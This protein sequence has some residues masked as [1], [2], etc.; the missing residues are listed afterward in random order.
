ME[1]TAAVV[2]YGVGVSRKVGIER[3]GREEA[4]AWSPRQDKL[5]FRFEVRFNYKSRLKFISEHDD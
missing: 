3:A 4:R 2:E 5:M 1:T